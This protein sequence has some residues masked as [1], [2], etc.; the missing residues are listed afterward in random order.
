MKFLLNSRRFIF[1]KH[2]EYCLS[3]SEILA[4]HPHWGKASQWVFWWDVH[5][6]V[7]AI[8]Y[9]LWKLLYGGIFMYCTM[10]HGLEEMQSHRAIQS[11]HTLLRVY[12]QTCGKK[13][14]F[15]VKRGYCCSLSASISWDCM[16]GRLSF[17]LGASLSLMVQWWRVGGENGSSESQR[18][19]CCQSVCYYKFLGN[20]SGLFSLVHKEKVG[21]KNGVYSVW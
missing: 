4:S 8:V 13:W 16:T 20:V 6:I 3:L 1:S 5:Q 12:W 18:A 2:E 7:V 9:L 17:C 11:C 14:F 10:V 21:K 19:P 15:W